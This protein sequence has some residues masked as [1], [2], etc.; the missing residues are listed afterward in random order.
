MQEHKNPS[1]IV[2]K[3]QTWNSVEGRHLFYHMFAVDYAA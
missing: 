1:N 3:M 2:E